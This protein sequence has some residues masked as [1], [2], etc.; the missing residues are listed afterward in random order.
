MI[1]GGVDFLAIFY[2]ISLQAQSGTNGSM[3]P[4]PKFQKGNEGCK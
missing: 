4:L 3:T 1:G 2:E